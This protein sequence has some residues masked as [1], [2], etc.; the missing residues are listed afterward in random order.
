M[1][2]LDANALN[3]GKD[4]VPNNDNNWKHY[5]SDSNNPTNP[6]GAA[7]VYQF[8]INSAT[9]VTYKVVSYTGGGLATIK[10]IG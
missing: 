5:F 2:D 3:I 1:F 4:T 6:A 8:K 9:K 7:G 10:K